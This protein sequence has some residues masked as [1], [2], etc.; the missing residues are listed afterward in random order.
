MSKQR[1]KVS[2][3]HQDSLKVTQA[4]CLPL[5]GIG[6]ANVLE[7]NFTHLLGPSI[8]TLGLH[9]RAFWNRNLLWRSIH[10]SRAAVDE[11]WTLCVLHLCQEIDEA[12][13]IDIVV[14]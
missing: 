8:Y 13:D 1:N 9:R 2:G 12:S 6:V 7:D 11:P 5:L 4:D 14:A 10:G 3:I